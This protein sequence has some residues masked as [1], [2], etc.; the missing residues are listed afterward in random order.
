MRLWITRLLAAGTLLLLVT[1]AALFALA[2]N[3]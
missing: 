1:L 3:P 2:Q